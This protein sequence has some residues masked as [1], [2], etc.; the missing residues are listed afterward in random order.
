[1]INTDC[2]CKGCGLRQVGCHGEC[3]E[4]KSWR[5]AKDEQSKDI[6]LK[7]EADAEVASYIKATKHREARNHRR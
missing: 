3:R 1:M 6:H 5:K 2:P 4:Y 7:M